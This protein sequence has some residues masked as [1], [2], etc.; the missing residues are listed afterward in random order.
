MAIIQPSFS[1]PE[2]DDSV[3]VVQWTGLLNGDTG[4]PAQL[5]KYADR[6][7]QIAGTFGAGG[8]ALIEG[9]N[10]GST[11]AT[12]NNTTGTALSLTTP[13][14]KQVLE[15]TLLIRPNITAGDGT[16]TLTV[17]ALIRTGTAIVRK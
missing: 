3:V 16:T 11:Y 14:I 9:S 12:L 1:R 5:T 4:A 7:V 8:T 10:D 2:G 15:N 13:Q 17:T 6:S